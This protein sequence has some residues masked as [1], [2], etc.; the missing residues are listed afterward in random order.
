[1]CIRDRGTDSEVIANCGYFFSE[2]VTKAQSANGGKELLIWLT[3]LPQLRKIFEGL[4]SMNNDLCSNSAAVLTTLNSYVLSLGSRKDELSL[5]ITQQFLEGFPAGISSIADA[6]AKD[7]SSIC[8]LAA[9]DLLR[10]CL[11]HANQKIS[12]EIRF[13]K[14]F[15]ILLNTIADHPWSNMLHSQIEKLLIAALD[16]N[17]NVLNEAIFVDGHL[18]SFLIELTQHPKHTF[19]RSGTIINQGFLGHV[20]KIANAITKRAKEGKLEPWVSDPAW[21]RFVEEYLE[22]AN[23]REMRELGVLPKP[24]I[25]ESNDLH[26]PLNEIADEEESLFVPFS[27]SKLGAPCVSP[28]ERGPGSPRNAPSSFGEDGFDE[29]SPSGQMV[30][31]KGRRRSEDEEAERFSANEFWRATLFREADFSQILGDYE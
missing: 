2:I 29:L 8:K 25:I 27:P 26:L 4:K 12:E 11:Q 17:S 28:K 15:P 16:Q 30:W 20:H 3:E 14:I 19:A 13:N 7:R 31:P 10:Q 9:I 6:L 24:V 22:S 1:M 21:K 18:L 5:K 23:E